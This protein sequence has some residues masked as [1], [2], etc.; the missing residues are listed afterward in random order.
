MQLRTEA[1]AA[2]RTPHA[3]SNFRARGVARRPWAVLRQGRR[4]AAQDDVRGG[5]AANRQPGRASRRDALDLRAPR[6]RPAAAGRDLLRR[7]VAA[8][9]AAPAPRR[10]APTGGP[11][12]AAAGGTSGP[13]RRARRFAAQSRARVPPRVPMERQGFARGAGISAAA[14]GRGARGGRARNGLP[15]GDRASARCPGGATRRAVAG[16]ASGASAGSD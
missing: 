11:G 14:S 1:R 12:S 9:E 2:R 10:S 3:D 7:F 6:G 16:G 8:R 13:R 15:A 4:E 5:P